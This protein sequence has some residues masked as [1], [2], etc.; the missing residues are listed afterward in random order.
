MDTMNHKM[1]G[2]PQQPK[3]PGF[4]LAHFTVVLLLFCI[5]HTAQADYLDHHFKLTCNPQNNLAEIIPYAVW[6]ESSYVPTTQECV[7]SKGRQIRAKLGTGPVYPYG[8]GGG[9]PERW[10]SVWVD[11]ALVLSGINIGCDDE[12]TCS[13]R[14]VV[15][16]KGLEV[17]YQETSETPLPQTSTKQP[18]YRCEFTPNEQILKKRDPIEYP[19]PNERKPPKAG[20]LATLYAKDKQFCSEFKLV[21]EANY[22]SYASDNISAP[23]G[24]PRE[25]EPIEPDSSS[26]Y[27]WSGK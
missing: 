10:I 11:K 20:S 5:S 14:I 2:F 23:I 16:A 24:L 12:G 13:P 7:L 26:P 4:V 19:L 8:F 21:S 22:R 1:G 9:D 17:C 15:T 3:P 27:E 6:N 25:A 18:E